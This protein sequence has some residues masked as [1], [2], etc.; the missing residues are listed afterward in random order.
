MMFRYYLGAR[1]RDVLHLIREMSYDSM[2]HL[3][4]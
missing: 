2:S 1:K 4:L 3:G